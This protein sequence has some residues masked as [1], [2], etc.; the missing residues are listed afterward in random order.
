MSILK[1]FW[2]GVCMY[3]IIFSRDW[4]IALIPLIIACMILL[5]SSQW[6]EDHIILDIYIMED[7]EEE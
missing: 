3:F 4:Y 1:S 5:T 2:F 6:W 7:E